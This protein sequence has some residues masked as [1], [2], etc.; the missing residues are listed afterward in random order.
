ML[1]NSGNKMFQGKTFQVK[2]TGGATPLE[3]TAFAGKTFQIKKEQPTEIGGFPVTYL[4]A[5]PPDTPD[6]KWTSQEI[7]ENYKTKTEFLQYKYPE[8]IDPIEYLRKG[9]T[10]GW[11]PDVPKPQATTV[12]QMAMETAGW[13]VSAVTLQHIASP[14]IGGALSKI[15]GVAKPLAKVTEEALKHPWKVGYPLT[16]TKGASWGAVFGAIEKSEN[17]TEW[18]RNVLRYAGTFAAFNVIAYPILQ[19]FKPVI[20]SLGTDKRYWA[21]PNIKKMLSTEGMAEIYTPPKTLYFQHPTNK[22]LVLRVTQE[23]IDVLPFANVPGP[24]Q[25]YP[26]LGRTEIEAFKAEPS[27]YNKLKDFLKGK[28]VSAEVPKAQ[29]RVELAVPKGEV[30]SI[31]KPPETIIPPVKPVVSKA[32]VQKDIFGKEVKVTVIPE[33]VELEFG[34]DKLALEKRLKRALTSEEFK[35]IKARELIAEQTGQTS[36]IVEGPK[37]IPKELEEM[38]RRALSFQ[39]A[40]KTA[41]NFE[42][43]ISETSPK[44]A[45]RILG[46][47]F[48]SLQDFYTQ[49]TR[50]AKVLATKAPVKPKALPE[51]ADEID[52]IVAGQR[53]MRVPEESKTDWRESVGKGAYM[54]IFSGGRLAETPDEVA[55][56]LGITENEL[57][58]QIIERLN[59]KSELAET[60]AYQKVLEKVKKLGPDSLT[61]ADY[62]IISKG[63]TETLTPEGTKPITPVDRAVDDLMELYSGFPIHKLKDISVTIRGTKTRLIDALGAEFI[64]YYGL[65]PEIRRWLIELDGASDVLKEDLSKFFIERFPVSKEQAKLL[66]LHQEQ[67]AK[68]PIPT[69]LQEYAKQINDLVE[70]SKRLQDE[71]GLQANF[72]PQSFIL[73]AERQIAQ[74]QE[75]V[76]ALKAKGPVKVPGYPALERAHEVRTQNLISKHLSSIQESTEYIEFLKGLKYIPHLYLQSEEIERNIIRLLPEGKITAKFRSAV[77]KLKGRKFATLEDAKEAGLVP[78]EDIRVLL[79]AHFEYLYRK[80]AIYDVIE[81]LKGVREAV[82]PENEAPRE[83]SKAAISQLDGYRVH[84]LLLRAIEDFAV[85]VSTSFIGKGYDAVNWLGKSIVFYNP[86]ILPFWNIFQGYAAGSVTPWKPFY[87]ASLFK[88]A[89]NDVI[90]RTELYKEALGGGLFRTAR[91]GHFSPPIESTMR[92]LTDKMEK[93]YPGWKKA[94]EKIIGKKVNWKTYA[95]LPDLYTTNWRL[96]W[97]ADR[98]Q[99]MATLRHA[100]NSGMSVP[101]AIEYT[102]TFHANYSIFTKRAKGW[103]NRLFLVPTYKANMLIGLPS[104]IGKNTFKLAEKVVKGEKVTPQEKGA[105]IG[106]IRIL[107]FW[108]SALSFA[109][110]RGYYLQEGYRLVKKLDKPELSSEGKVLTERV[111]TLPGPFAE[112]PKALW[113]LKEGPEGLFM[114]MA[115]VPQIAWSLMRNARWTGDPYWTEGASPDYQKREIIVNLLRDYV[116]PVDRLALAS[117]EENEAMDNILSFLGLATYKRGGVERRILWEISQEKEKMQKFLQRPDISTLDK[118]EAMEAYQEKVQSKI[119]ELADYMETY[120]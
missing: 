55:S 46:S 56:S 27:I 92:V 19:F 2:P 75:A 109:A 48:V 107:V 21:D 101:E 105:F 64:R 112:I 100:V 76:A 59:G 99:R 58:D 44:M 53:K 83:W 96:T 26:I 70:L 77:T 11:G 111:I 108:A 90:N 68:Y 51:W 20:Y 9:V 104:F 89:W 86:V 93:D 7:K 4:R 116:A 50:G 115:K 52:R 82:L 6:L 71:R 79:G 110:W 39:E 85:P 40:G 72:F 49:A 15:P 13:L 37:A 23:R 62:E 36:I 10:F 78:E 91:V 73:N 14:L 32:V 5:A 35:E 31:I 84:P 74:H 25:T 67:P 8:K 33:Q 24:M 38:R 120:K 113:R 47:G 63:G 60:T 34:L 66:T 30:P 43:F 54:K 41:E 102:N 18:A 103:M 97:G 28:V 81:Q 95:V 12:R 65:T 42:K 98:V 117:E 29:P 118:Q 22:S 80:I 94:V 106:L 119:D 16:V 69:E 114:Y 87:T 57:R 61:P 3:N 45:K 1:L 17:K 88:Q